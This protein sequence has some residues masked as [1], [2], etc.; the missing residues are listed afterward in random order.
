MSRNRFLLYGLLVFAI[1]GPLV[2]MTFA[3]IQG[4]ISNGDSSKLLAPIILFIPSYFFG[5]PIALVYGAAST[6]LLL[7]LTV[8][9][10]ELPQ[11]SR[12]VRFTI[13]VSLSATV[14]IGTGISFGSLPEHIQFVL[15]ASASS[16]RALSTAALSLWRLESTAL[17]TFGMPTLICNVI[18]GLLVWPRLANVT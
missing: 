17:M 4:A 18:V 12:I 9:K 16:E 11:S 8:L 3:G 13:A 2:P 10:P 1:V 15:S 7:L 14:V 5:L 6:A